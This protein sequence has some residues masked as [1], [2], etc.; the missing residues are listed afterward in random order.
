MQSYYEINVSMAG[1]HLFATAPR[2]L[3]QKSDFDKVIRIIR[4]KFPASEGFKVTS[5]HWTCEGR[6]L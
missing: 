1:T 4:A 6:V 5:V 2:S 3:V